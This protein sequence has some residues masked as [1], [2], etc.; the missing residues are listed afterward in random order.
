MYHGKILRDQTGE[1]T[2]KQLKITSNS[3]LVI[4]VLAEPELLEPN[5]M[6]LL[7]CRRN[8]ATRTYGEK[9]ELKFTYAAKNFPNIPELLAA[10]KTHLGLQ[11]SDEVSLA[12]YVPHLFEWKYLDPTEE[13]TETQGKKKKTTIKTPA[14]Q[15]DLRKFP[16]LLNDGDII[17]VRLESEVDKTVPLEQQDDFQTEADSAAREDF[18]ILQEKERQDKEKN[19]NTKGGKRAVEHGIVFNTDF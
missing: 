9:T 12:K 14:T 13:I 7:A 10:C 5:Q 19:R 3:Q 11:D 2:L 16:Y 17:G 6:I 4:Q 18:K 1:Q 15:F 8:V